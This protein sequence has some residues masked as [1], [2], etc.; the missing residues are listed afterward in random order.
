MG[1]WLIVLLLPGC[2]GPNKSSG[3]IRERLKA[4]IEA[5]LDSP[6]YRVEGR[7]VG[8]RREYEADFTI[9]RMGGERARVISNSGEDPEVVIGRVTY[10]PDRDRRGF[11]AYAT[12][13]RTKEALLAVDLALVLLHGI[14]NVE[15]VT[16]DDGVFR[17]MLRE[18]G[19]VSQAARGEL[20]TRSERVHRISV[21]GR[22]VSYS[23]LFRYV[24]VPPIRKPPA[25]RIVHE[26]AVPTCPP[27][28][29]L[30][31]GTCQW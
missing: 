30:L 4:A 21:G 20:T 9:D 5:T 14:R 2:S 13:S 6:S 15:Q 28:E 26:I 10:F 29:N 12:F 23:L 22:D 7:V 1:V 3:A 27:D 25:N 19:S 24:D 17:F 16:E 11:Y 8:V 31:P 18:R